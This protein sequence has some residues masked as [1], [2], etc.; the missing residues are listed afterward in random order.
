MWLIESDINT[1]FLH[2]DVS[3]IHFSKYID[4]ENII[5]VQYLNLKIRKH[6]IV[7]SQRVEWSTS[8]EK[9]FYQTSF[10]IIRNCSTR[11]EFRDCICIFCPLRMRLKRNLQ[12]ISSSVG[13][14]PV[15]ARLRSQVWSV[16]NSRSLMVSMCSSDLPSVMKDFLRRIS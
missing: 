16:R 9:L 12:N 8:R 14:L 3:S 4:L 6:P 1:C 5:S 7:W 10:Y 15:N 13:S 11:K 2:L